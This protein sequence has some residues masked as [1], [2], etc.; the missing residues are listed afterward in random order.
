MDRKV[1]KKLEA[2]VK[3]VLGF[4]VKKKKD[5]EAEGRKK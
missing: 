5:S 1:K 2:M 4:K 3:K